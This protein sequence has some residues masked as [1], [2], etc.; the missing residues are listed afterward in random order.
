[1]GAI[2][3]APEN[4]NIWSSERCQKARMLGKTH[5]EEEHGEKLISFIRKYEFKD[6][7]FQENKEH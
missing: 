7:R 5:T 1:M 3:E 4:T 6:E 2:E